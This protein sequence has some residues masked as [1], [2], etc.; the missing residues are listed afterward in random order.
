MRS[1]LEGSPFG[2][3][4]IYFFSL[5]RRSKPWHVGAKV[6]SLFLSKLA[7]S[8]LPPP[9]QTPQI[10]SKQELFYW[11]V[12][13]GVPSCFSCRQWQHTSTSS[14]FL[15]IFPAWLLFFLLFLS[16]WLLTMPGVYKRA[17]LLHLFILSFL[18][19]FTFGGGAV[20]YSM[21]SCWA[22]S[23]ISVIELDP[24]P[25]STAPTAITFSA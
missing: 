4:G 25:P 18:Y 20:G 16:L 15:S 19:A 21:Q 22:T 9:P 14:S 1:F 7:Y 5:P 24:L 8:R 23:V 2:H 12:V 10:E 6:G 13:F 11:D 3:F 17:E